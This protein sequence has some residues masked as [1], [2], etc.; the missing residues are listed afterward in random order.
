VRRGICF[1]SD[2]RSALSSGDF[3]AIVG[4]ALEINPGLCERGFREKLHKTLWLTWLLRLRF[5]LP[6]FD[7]V[8]FGDRFFIAGSRSMV[9]RMAS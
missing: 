3:L 6:V 1:S 7:K 2:K 8:R 4:L 9:A 5:K